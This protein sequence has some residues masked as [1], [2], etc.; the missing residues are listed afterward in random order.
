MILANW[1]NGANIVFTIIAVIIMAFL[2]YLLFKSFQK[3]ERNYRNEQAELMDGVAKKSE[4]ISYVNNYITRSPSTLVFA[5]LLFEFDNLLELQ[6]A[7]GE[8][9]RIF[10]ANCLDNWIRLIIMD[11]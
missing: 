3:E 10:H 7:F 4:I 8:N 6:N 11:S 5:M 1:N 2:A 9:N